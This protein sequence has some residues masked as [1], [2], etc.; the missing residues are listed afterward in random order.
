MISLL[1]VFKEFSHLV[2]KNFYFETLC[3]TILSV[4]ELGFP[5]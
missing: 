2:I 1:F 3:F 5:V 4:E